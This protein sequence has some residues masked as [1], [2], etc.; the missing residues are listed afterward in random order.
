[1]RSKYIK[2]L[3]G[4][5]VL[6]SLAAC[7][8]SGS[9]PPS[10]NGGGSNSELS[11]AI[12]APDQYP[13]GVAVTAYLTMTN[14]SNVN[15]TNL[16]YEVPNN[17]NYTGAEITIANDSTQPCK[18][19][20]AGQSCTFP[21]T[22]AANSHPGSFTVI[23]TPNTTNT[24]KSNQI[25][26]SIK[27]VIGL[28]VDA[29]SLTANIGLTNV[30]AN[31]QSGANGI[32]FLYS[33]TIAA[34]ESEPTKIAI[35]AVVNSASAGTF[36]T[37]NLTDSVHN[38]LNFTVSSG[39]SG[40]GLTNLTQGSI[41]TF[42]LTIPAGITNYEFYAQ[43]KEDNIVVSNGATAN[44]IGLSNAS[45]GI[46]A[47][48]P[49]NF[50]LSASSSYTSQIVTYT[51]IGNAAIT[52]L[53]V[54]T[55]EGPF[56][57]SNNCSNTLAAGASCT[58][59]L[60][61]TAAPGVAGSASLTAS[62]SAGS[63]V[64]QF[65][66]AGANA[67][68]GLNVEAAN[69]FLFTSNTVNA[70]ESTQV[71][72]TNSGNVNESNFTFDFGGNSY[73]TLATGSSGTPCAIIN[74]T[75]AGPLAA[76]ESCTLTLTYTNSSLTQ[77]NTAI[78][79]INY[80]AN[81]NA[82]TP[83]VSKTITYS[84]IQASANLS[85]TPASPYTFATILA[86]G[87]DSKTTTFTFTNNGPDTTSSITI[88][89]FTGANAEYF[90]VL[91]PSSPND[92]QNQN[93]Q[94]L[95]IGASCT[96]TIKFGTTLIANDAVTATLPLTI[97]SVTGGVSNSNLVVSGMAVAPGSAILSATFETESNPISFGFLNS[98][99]PY[100]LYFNQ[101]G[102]LRFKVTNTG[103]STATNLQLVQP[104][105]DLNICH[106]NTS[107][108]NACGYDGNIF[109]GT[110]IGTTLAVRAS[111][112]V[113]YTCNSSSSFTLNHNN[114][115]GTMTFSDD[116]HPSGTFQQ[117]V[118]FASGF[119]VNIIPPA[120]VTA[121]LSSES[122]G[123]ESITQV[124]VGSDFYVV[125]TLNGG[126]QI[127]S[128][129]YTANA[130]TG[131]TPTSSSCNISSISPTC[132]IKFTAPN[133][134]STSN[135]ISF[136]GPTAINPTS[137][138]IDVVPLGPVPYAYI[139]A[140][141][142]NGSSYI[143]RCIVGTNAMP[144]NCQ[145]QD[146]SFAGTGNVYQDV[147]FRSFSSGKYLYAVY[148]G[149]MKKCNLDTSGVITGCT[150]PTGIP[151]INYQYFNFGLL[152][153]WTMAFMTG[154]D[155]FNR[156]VIITCYS[157]DNPDDFTGSNGCKYSFPTF[158]PKGIGFINANG[159]GTNPGSYIYVNYAGTGNSGKGKRYTFNQQGGVNVDS[160]FV[161]SNLN[162]SYSLI[163]DHYSNNVYS[164]QYYNGSSTVSTA[165]QCSVNQS[166]WAFDNCTNNP[167]LDTDNPS[168]YAKMAGLLEQTSGQNYVYYSTNTGN[169]MYVCSI[170]SDNGTYSTCSSTT[171]GIWGN[172]S[173]T[174][175]Y[176]IDFA[177]Y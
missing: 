109:G 157:N 153:G 84:T 51:N 33:Q 165:T 35:V 160:N 14:T 108:S 164:G 23:A 93:K 43:T 144:S 7:S 42:L 114:N 72:I 137:L 90:S 16:T 115:L 81:G 29:L 102:I 85:S 32:T 154:I 151:A 66:Y 94:T 141:E 139:A 121:V 148:N 50:S 130:P 155:S 101:N 64:S 150:N 99:S 22:I 125:F 107:V 117:P 19:I 28:K 120:S 133:T 59:T 105:T 129:A 15:A 176:G 57:L 143:Y 127:S 136:S 56:S 20:L 21:A 39:N 126:Y 78:M 80:F 10:T 86:N 147:H 24:N 8:G 174:T 5:F 122:A 48:K 170:N 138:N 142:S 146:N 171:A 18:N 77:S 34:S 69:N 73:F 30:P 159:A 111:C 76:S 103:T 158:A 123:T 92:C 79:S 145:R 95:A 27:S 2:N 175:V 131:F 118:P 58:V 152:N 17:T 96:L 119:D 38:P 12:T 100:Y 112:Y 4:A 87:R 75:V 168:N 149:G 161:D 46:L 67:V 173:V 62:S 31:S 163:L 110:S 70:S 132:Y 156:P 74:N 88:G 116:A 167:S 9:C 13:A 55:P 60:T 61:S 82:V 124:S 128:Q 97:N 65:N 45:T 162:S 11:L 113:Q 169:I 83:A 54:D 36:N 135:A 166:T 89:T 6:V 140:T 106:L 63:A 40:K 68:S 47:V 53:A 25:L 134:S 26:A 1:M 37:I 44:L 41:V 52:H 104:F 98:T 172:N 91:T 177:T 71:T 3:L 49:T